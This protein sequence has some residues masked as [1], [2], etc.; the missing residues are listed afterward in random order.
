MLILA[1]GGAGVRATD[2]VVETLIGAAV[3]LLVDCR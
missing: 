2:R 1:A 3:G